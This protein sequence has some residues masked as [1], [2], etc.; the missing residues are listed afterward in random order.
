VSIETFALRV[1]GSEFLPPS[2]PEI[3]PLET[4]EGPDFF[5]PI[6]T[7]NAD[8]QS[9]TR[10]GHLYTTVKFRSEIR[11]LCREAE[12]SISVKM[13]E[14]KK[15]KRSPVPEYLY[16]FVAITLHREKFVAG[17]CAK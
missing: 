11:S 4:P 16:G 7:P 10:H 14:L 3:W 2:F 12:I 6:Y 15:L 17:F 13:C 5:T 8:L 9:L 1:D